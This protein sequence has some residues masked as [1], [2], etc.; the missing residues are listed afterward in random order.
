MTAFVNCHLSFYIERQAIALF[1]HK[2]LL[3]SLFF[4]I[5]AFS[6]FAATHLH[7]ATASNVFAA[8]TEDFYKEVTPELEPGDRPENLEI[9]PQPFLI[10]GPNNFNPSLKQ[11]S[12]P[13]SPLP[14]PQPVVSPQ[15][16]T[17]PDTPTASVQPPL[18]LEN[19]ELNFRNDRDNFG[20]ENQFFE[21]TFGLRLDNGNRLQV[22][23][24]Y[25]TFSLEDVETVSN[26]PVQVGYET[27]IDDYTIQAGLGVDLFNRLSTA[28]N[29]NA[30]VDKPIGSSA[31]LS[32]IVEQGPYKFNART[33]ENE[34]T[35]LRYGTNLFWQIDPN[36]SFFS[37]LRLGNYN[38]GNVE[39]QSFT[40]LERKLGQFFVAANLFNW[41]YRN[42]VQD[43]SGYFSPPDFLVYNGEVGWE[44]QIFEFLRCRLAANIGQQR[45][46]GEW[47]AGN[48]YQG[49]CTTQISPNVDADFGYS[50][51]NVRQQGS[52]E[53][54]YNNRTFTGV[55]RVNF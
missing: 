8:Q 26:I 34:I 31:T 40:R 20:R 5:L 21:P 39:Q 29:F 30:R 6:I 32:G 43:T 54:A 55:L 19:L 37:S 53:D 11:A 42:D 10:A 17:P 45:L 41:S 18:K 13:P 23:T 51:S 48:T 2:L 28:L 35:A 24:G 1:S 25:N 27:K 50:Y 3:R 16:V 47:S 44:G 9:Q 36:T 12:P 33:L 4:S 46:E 7:A 22:R 15:P 49:R 52:N 38:D 14:S